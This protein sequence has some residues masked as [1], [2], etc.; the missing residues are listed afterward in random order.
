MHTPSFSE[1]PLVRALLRALLF[2]ASIE[3]IF[4]RLLTIPARSARPWV[5]G[6]HVSTE[7]AGL[8]MF[9]VAFALLIPTLLAIAYSTLRSPAWSGGLN[10]LV[11]LGLLALTAMTISAAFGPRGPAF[12]LGF[13]LLAAAVALA[14]LSGLYE[15]RSDLAGRAFAVLLAGAVACMA[16]SGAVDL[17]GRIAPYRPGF[18][19][20]AVAAAGQWLFIAAGLL[21]FPAFAPEAGSRP[22]VVGHAAGLGLSAA[23]AFTLIVGVVAHPP[24]LSRLGASLGAAWPGSGAGIA[25]TAAAAAALFLTLLTCVSI[26][27]DPEGRGRAYGLLLL[28]LAGY[29]H[30]IAYQHL[31]AL[32]GL[33]LL[34]G[35]AFRRPPVVLSFLEAG[36]AHAPDA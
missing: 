8:L 1:A 4:H 10:A 33:A 17:L 9:Y 28:L 13:S 2:A 23:S 6:L 24:I 32:A 27:N 22:G 29:P 3:A 36:T 16:S 34:T 5:E 31:L 25:T 21:A 20:A 30:G 18:P 35:T 14:M 15:A 26:F 11:W 19:V 7:R 12:A